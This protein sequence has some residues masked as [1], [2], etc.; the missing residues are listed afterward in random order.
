MAGDPLEA[1]IQQEIERLNREIDDLMRQRQAYE[2]MLTRARR[3]NV[4]MRDVTRKNSIP[5]IMIES[6]V[7]EMLRI[8]GRRVSG[9]DLYRD[10]RFSNAQLN[11]NTFRT[12]LMR[13][14]R[15]DMIEGA[16]RGYWKLKAQALSLVAKNEEISN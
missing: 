2:V 3:E 15:K 14:K 5:R 10:A 9:S 16:G 1:R 12:Q 11:Y 7:M 13:M 8:A 6:R 4:E